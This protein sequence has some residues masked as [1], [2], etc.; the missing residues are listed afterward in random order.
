MD[1]PENVAELPIKFE[2]HVA[3]VLVGKT[4]RQRCLDIERGLL[5]LANTR[6]QKSKTSQKAKVGS[7]YVAREQGRGSFRE[8]RD[9]SKFL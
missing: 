9:K 2:V 5:E 7:F 4:L 8:L 3:D 1:C 6:G